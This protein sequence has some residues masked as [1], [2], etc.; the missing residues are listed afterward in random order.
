M[1][2]PSHDLWPSVSIPDHDRPAVVDCFKIVFFLNREACS[3]VAPVLNALALFLGGL[4][5]DKLHFYVNDEGDT[6][7]LPPN[8]MSYVSARLQHATLEGKVAALI[9]LST[10]GW[11]GRYEVKY[12]HAPNISPRWPEK[13]SYLWF[14]VDRECLRDE[15]IEVVVDFV[16]SLSE[17]LPFSYGYASPA[18]SY[19]EFISHVSPVIR[20]MPGFDVA[21]P[22]AIAMD[23]GDRAL[24]AYWLNVFN[25]GLLQS[26]GG[27]ASIAS[28][29]PE[30][31]LTSVGAGGLLL[32]LGH[33]PEVGDVNRLNDL[34]LYRRLA[35]ILE[36]QLRVPK[37]VFF[38]DDGNNSAAELQSWWHRRFL[39]P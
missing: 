18:L 30:A 14:H 7:S 29:I 27:T 28:K 23:I 10:A 16:R 17:L 15:G 38:R 31:T 2:S 26:L 12:Y 5:R 20:R 34:P 8:P 6:Q 13:R 36:P 19:G 39:S 3:N 33:L 37:V 35:A 21:H 11:G 1:V 9:L 22:G 25:R 32:R 24:G 4:G